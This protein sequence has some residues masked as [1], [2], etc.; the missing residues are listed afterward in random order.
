[1]IDL[2]D[3]NAVN[4]WPVLVVNRFESHIHAIEFSSF[5]N[6]KPVKFKNISLRCISPKP[7]TRCNFLQLLQFVYLSDRQW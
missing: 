5:H 2:L 6:W 4:G 7:K 1:M 3:F